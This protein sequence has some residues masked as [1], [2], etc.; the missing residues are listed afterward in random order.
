MDV[1]RCPLCTERV[2]RLLG[3]WDRVGVSLEGANFRELRTGEVSRTPSWRSSQNSPSRGWVDKLL[4]HL[5][6]CLYLLATVVRSKNH[7]L[8]GCAA[9][10][11]RGSVG[12]YAKGVGG[13]SPCSGKRRLRM[14]RILSLVVVAL[15]VAAMVLVMAITA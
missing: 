4:M 1:Y 9:P 6:H 8:G 14:K 15:I 2:L 7:S 11:P 13:L 12:P 10:A 5:A 3:A